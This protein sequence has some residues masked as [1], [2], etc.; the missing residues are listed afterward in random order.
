MLI[1]GSSPVVAQYPLMLESTACDTERWR[2]KM[3][4][5]ALLQLA[6]WR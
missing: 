6:R 1:S 5:I 2:A 3:I 4:M